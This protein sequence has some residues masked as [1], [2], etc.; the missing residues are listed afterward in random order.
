[1][2]EGYNLKK[3]IASSPSAPRNDII[4][5]L[6]II[7]LLAASTSYA[8]D[9]GTIKASYAT[10]EHSQTDGTEERDLSGSFDFHKYRIS[11]TATP[12]EDY[13]YRVSLQDYRKDFAGSSDNL[14]TDTIAT[15]TSL[16][17]PV[18]KTEENQLRGKINYS[19]LTKRYKDRDSLEYDKNSI[20]G[21][22]D[23]NYKK[24][25][26]VEVSGGFKDYEYIKAPSSDLSKV[27]LKIS[28]SV[29][30]L[31]KQLSI[32]GYY[33]RQWADRASDLKD[34]TED[35]LS[36]R[37][38]LK[39]DTP[40][41]RKIKGHFQTGRNDTLE[42]EEDREDTLRFR[43]DLWDLTTYH[44]IQE[45]IDTQFTYGQTYRDYYT[46]INSYDNWFIKNKTKFRILKKEPFNLDLILAAGHKETDFY[47][48]DIL[49]YIK[50]SLSAGLNLL[51]REEWSL[52]SNLKYTGYDYPAG[53]IND[54]K[55]YQLK[56]SGRRYINTWDSVL[57]ARYSYKWKDYKAKADAQQ[58]TFDIS[59]NVQF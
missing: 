23:F 40:I 56:L 41:F 3:G 8:S 57:E 44:K 27:F 33:K 50:D 38:F 28:P 4:F 10:G 32:S 51:E 9:L 52:R 21:S 39:I 7:S 37:S 47:E 11:V 59:L 30:L 5:Y 19:N 13:K 24:T 49:G 43:Y 26:S 46:S 42:S 29:K 14:D 55:S 34:Y 6:F 58:W 45:D 1:V 22:L 18:Y 15:D 48:N 17:L 53:S 16:A 25:Y 31:D 36:V 20:S 12:K 35:T 54:Q 2:P